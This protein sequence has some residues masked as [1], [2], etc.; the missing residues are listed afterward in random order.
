VSPPV[1]ASDHVRALNALR[2]LKRVLDEAFR[3]PGTNITFGWDAI[4]GLVPWAGDVLTSLLS[5]AIIVQAHRMRIPR[6][7]VVRMLLNVALDFVIGV[8]P[9]VGDIADVF[10]KSNTKN[11]ALLEHHAAEVRP[12]SRGDWLFV[13][14]ILGAVLAMAV[15]PLIVLYLIVQVIVGHG[16]LSPYPRW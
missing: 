1:V 3:V 7:V 14:G 16:G 15:V 10:W 6:V 13:I 5:C 11:F 4:I 8:V 2:S 12:A 9:V